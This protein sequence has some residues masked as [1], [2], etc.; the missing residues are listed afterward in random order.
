M[1]SETEETKDTNKEPKEPKDVKITGSVRDLRRDG[2]NISFELQVGDC[3]RSVEDLCTRF[4]SGSCLPDKYVVTDYS[5]NIEEGSRV[6]VYVD[7]VPTQDPRIWY[8]SKERMMIRG[9]IGR[10]NELIIWTPT[11]DYIK[12]KPPQPTQTSTTN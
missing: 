6:Q 7:P 8:P 2:N 1:T 9:L 12:P 5:G 3:G 4:V 11:V 10:V